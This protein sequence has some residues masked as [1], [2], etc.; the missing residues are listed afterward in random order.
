MTTRTSNLKQ[1]PSSRLL[2]I[3]KHNPKAGGGSIID[4]LKDVKHVSYFR[5][6]VAP[7]CNQTSTAAE[8]WDQ[9]QKLNQ[10]D[11]LVI[12]RES[13]T[14]Y[15]EDR[16]MG[17]VISSIR[18]PCDH[19]V[20]L[21]SF[22]SSGGGGLFHKSNM[23]RPEWT[24]QAYGRDPPTF[25]SP[26]D[27]DAFRN[28]WL[29]DEKIQGLIARRHMISFGHENLL[30]VTSGNLTDDFYQ[31]ML[32]NVDCWVYVDDFQASLYHCLWKYEAQ[33]GYVNWN[34]PLLSEL[35]HDL[36]QKNRFETDL[37]RRIKSVS[38]Q[39]KDD[40]L[41][42]PQLSHHSKCSE[43]YD[44]NSS[45]LVRYGAE[46]FIYDMFEYEG[47]CAGRRNSA[48]LLLQY[49]RSYDRHKPNELNAKASN[50]NDGITMTML[51]FFTILIGVLVSTL[52]IRKIKKRKQ[53]LTHEYK[54]DIVSQVM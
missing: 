37:G 30:N 48:N 25:C 50:V 11:S 52:S 17:Y 15:D 40:V 41:G 19:Y 1:T 12:I 24:H 6:E 16:E 29:R 32:K 39:S 7:H 22:G 38:T 23:T 53:V 36:D 13:E 33:G 14:V 31:D 21:W 46:A 4:L 5:K 18:E 9:L 45:A 51:S 35:I 49:P 3:F 28:I 43:Y 10:N 26:R 27:I 54:Y 2:L 34:A 42:N 44:K 47:C 20:S 8:K